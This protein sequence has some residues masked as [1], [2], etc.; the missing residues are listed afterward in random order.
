MGMANAQVKNAAESGPIAKRRRSVSG[1]VDASPVRPSAN[2]CH[3]SPL[4]RSSIDNGSVSSAPTSAAPTVAATSR[5]TPVGLI[6]TSAPATRPVATKTVTTATTGSKMPARPTATP[7]AT[8]A[9]TSP[10]TG[11]SV[12]RKGT[13]LGLEER[14]K[15]PRGGCVDAEGAPRRPGNR[16]PRQRECGIGNER[17][18][19][20][21]TTTRDR[22]NPPGAD[23]PNE[24]RAKHP[25]CAD[26]PQRAAKN[27]G[28]DPE[29]AE[30]GGC[31]ADRAEIAMTPTRPPGVDQ[32]AA[33]LRERHE[34]T[35]GRHAT[36][37]ERSGTKDDQA[38]DER[39]CE[40]RELGGPRAHR[41]D[42]FSAKRPVAATDLAAHK[43]VDS[44]RA[45]LLSGP[46]LSGR[47]RDPGAEARPSTADLVEPGE[48]P[49]PR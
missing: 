36:A 27:G 26:Q 11:P 22:K 49:R 6:V 32:F 3:G 7:A 28:K 9:E 18:D 1:S 19:L 15:N 20:G 12:D 40:Y 24:H 47:D 37:D 31:R 30:A 14:P 13:G 48:V 5:A 39:P 41:R 17:C 44:N 38:E 23:Q 4:L 8:D 46:N 21:P 25:Q 33:R 10:R 43:S 16:R 42:E 29:E 35:N 2:G 45:R 34:V